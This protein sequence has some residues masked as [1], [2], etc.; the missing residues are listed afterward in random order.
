MSVKLFADALGVEW[1]RLREMYPANGAVETRPVGEVR[2][3]MNIK[4]KPVTM[5]SMLLPAAS[6]SEEQV[7]LVLFC[8]APDCVSPLLDGPRVHIGTVQHLQRHGVFLSPA[9]VPALF[10][11]ELFGQEEASGEQD[12]DD[13]SG[14]IANND[15]RGLSPDRNK[16]SFRRKGVKDRVKRGRRAVS[17]E[18]LGV[19]PDSVR[20]RRRHDKMRYCDG[21]LKHWRK[22][23][24]YAEMEVAEILAEAQARNILVNDP[25][26]IEALVHGL[27]RDDLDHKKLAPV[28]RDTHNQKLPAML[29]HEN[30]DRGV[31]RKMMSQIFNHDDCL[32]TR[33]T[34]KQIQAELAGRGLPTGTSG[35]AR[36]KLISY[37]VRQDIAR[38][39]E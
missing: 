6:P 5:Q 28:K 3:D 24:R 14:D 34:N 18:P 23:S 35:M 32:Y 7:E 31:W 38:W 10:G 9:E 15:E 8:N 20:L 1:S 27:L 2:R 22:K 37:L 26:E 39:R 11:Y 25:E 36:K 12:V 17:V 19:G 29:V 16:A 4:S 21:H 33:W 30:A 13:P